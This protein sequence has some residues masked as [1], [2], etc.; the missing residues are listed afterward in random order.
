MKIG[1]KTPSENSGIMVLILRLWSHLTR[2][3]RYQMGLITGLT[4]ASAVAEVVSLGA[5]LPFIGVL[6]SPE[7]VFKHH[8]VAGLAQLLGF[9][10]ADQLI[11][12][13]TLMFCIAVV[14]ANAIRLLLL[15]SNTRFAYIIG[16]DL[17]AEA[18]LRTL[19][20]P[21]QMHLTR[22]SSEVISGVGKAENG[23]VVLSGLMTMLTAGF[24]A[25]CI[26]SALMVIDFMMATSV[27]LG[28][29][30]A[31]ALVAWAIRRR[32]KENSLIIAKEGNLRIKFLQEGLG[33]IRDIL[34]QGNQLVY[35]NTYCNSDL[36]FRRSQ[37]SNTFL[38]HSP[39]YFVEALSLSLVIWLAYTFSRQAGKT[40]MVLPVL[41]A[42][43]LGA[44][45]L[46]PA[47][48]QIYS[49]WASINSSRVSLEDVLDLI[50]QPYQ[51]EVLLPSPPPLDFRD[52]IRFEFVKFRY[53][54]ES[55]LVLDGFD[56][57]IPKG[58]R[59]GFVGKTGSGKSTMLDILMGLLKP[60]S[61]RILVDGL[62]LEGERVRAWQQRIAHVPQS[63]FLADATVAEN[64]AFGET[65]RDINM[66]RVRKVARQAHVDEF[67][68]NSPEGYTRL[69]GERG[70]RLSGGQRQRVGIARAL[71]KNASVLV[72][73]EATS[74]LDNTV[75]L[76]IM[77]SIERL[78]R[79]LTIIIVAHRLSTVR[80]CDLIVELDGGKVLAK[81][82]FDQL[83]ANSPSF[84]EMA[85]FAKET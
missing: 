6:T 52:G 28:T 36:A 2:R 27:F 55:P 17:G 8:N 50:D 60:V 58:A 33:A 68:E 63:I 19:Y 26:V 7:R 39:R 16:H 57:M 21:Y 20:Q 38:A 54:T 56:L 44:Q 41:G 70:T 83:L 29:G 77:E 5:V 71:Y 64:I 72:F 15:W 31:Y 79:D 22:N 11:L 82:T 69:I 46:L 40:E 75:E 84:R 65:G 48:Q 45:R 23:I 76:G 59:I 14:M 42:L 3:R 43:A 12:P 34:I 32:L 67:I 35:L 62:P 66:D 1:N 51:E 10:S 18:Y 61:G 4:F 53:S 73:D 47:L 74:A 13:I 25:A 24:T 49:S 37:G 85:M 78:G 81:G 30:C 9:T 80:S